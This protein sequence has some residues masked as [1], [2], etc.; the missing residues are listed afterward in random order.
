[1]TARLTVFSRNSLVQLAVNVEQ[2]ELI[3]KVAK[4]A[5]ID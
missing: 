5:H 4:Y 2:L 1:M 3:L